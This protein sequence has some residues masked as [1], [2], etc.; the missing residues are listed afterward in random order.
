MQLSYHLT[1]TNDATNNTSTKIIDDL[2]ML[3]SSISKQLL[4]CRI[5]LSKPI[6]RHDNGKANLTIRNVNKHLSALQSECIENDNISSQHLGR[7]GL[8]LNPKGKGRLALNFM[9]QIR[10]F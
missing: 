4:S 10:K 8:H 3:K 6:I 1:G 5:V 7:K 2:V 9:K